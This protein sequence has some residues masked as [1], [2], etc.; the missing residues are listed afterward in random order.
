MFESNET[1]KISVGTISNHNTKGVCSEKTCNTVKS[2]FMKV[3]FYGIEFVVGLCK[4]H[5]DLVE[6]KIFH[7]LMYQEEI[8]GH[9]LEELYPKT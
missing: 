9:S 2:H 1:L 7:E 6:D 8:C 4:R 5:Y 3:E